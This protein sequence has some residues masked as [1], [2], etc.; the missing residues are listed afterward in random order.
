MR[1]R[2]VQHGIS[3][4]IISLPSKW[5]KQYGVLK[6]EELELKENGNK[7]EI[8][9]DKAV[10]LS[11][12][13]IDVSQMPFTLVSMCILSAY[14]KGYD[15]VLLTY[16]TE[17]LKVDDETVRMTTFVRRNLNN[18]VGM[19]ITKEA[20][21]YCILNDVSQ[22]SS[23][24]FSNL[25]RRIFLLLTYEARMLKQVAYDSE[26]RV[27]LYEQSE[28]VKKLVAYCQRL[29]NKVSH[30]DPKEGYN[31][32]HMLSVIET[33]NSEIRDC[34]KLATQKINS[35]A[36]TIFN[37]IEC[38]IR[39]YYELHFGFDIGKA[40]KIIET[41]NRF[42]ANKDNVTNDAL[43]IAAKSHMIHKLVKNLVDSRLSISDYK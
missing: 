30:I 14:K 4:M 36:L 43:H 25:L 17:Y 41:C 7:L 21:G 31:T 10:E 12:I 28:T 27:E 32:Y 3:T 13:Q 24:E 42:L 1:R 37:E 18:L 2:V 35:D 23:K 34:A 22:P 5:V 33:I 11:S 8:S 19:E 39:M 40:A 26:V 16:P 20:E 29:I 9:I 15:E 38:I 6:G